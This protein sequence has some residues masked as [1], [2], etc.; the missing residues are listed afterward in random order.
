[1]YYCIVLLHDLQLHCVGKH[2]G[3]HGCAPSVLRGLRLQEQFLTTAYLAIVNLSLAPLRQSTRHPPGP[4]PY[5]DERVRSAGLTITGVFELPPAPRSAGDRWTMFTQVSSSNPQQPQLLIVSSAQVV[6]AALLHSR[7]SD[8]LRSKSSMYIPEVNQA[9]MIDGDIYGEYI[10]THPQCKPVHSPC[11]P[12]CVAPG[13][14]RRP[15]QNYETER[16]LS[17]CKGTGPL[18]D[19]PV[20]AERLHHRTETRC[21]ELIHVCS[22]CSLA[23][24]ASLEQEELVPVANILQICWGVVSLC[25][26][27]FMMTRAPK[28]IAP[29]PQ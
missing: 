6:P 11:P 16:A 2:S 7:A 24:T 3:K 9:V 21:T 26:S 29:T 8:T 23:H 1:M 15:K 4:L 25:Q 14:S 12:W 18:L 5:P 19:H 17:G 28:V 10:F 20:V 27:F 22:Q 13:S